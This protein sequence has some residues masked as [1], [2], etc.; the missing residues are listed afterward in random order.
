MSHRCQQDVVA[1]LPQ[2]GLPHSP[3]WVTAS[4]VLTPTDS[5]PYML[6]I[7]PGS[8]WEKQKKWQMDKA[9][10]VQKAPSSKQCFL[11]QGQSRE[12]TGP[13]LVCRSQFEY[14]WENNPEELWEAQIA[15][16]SL[17]FHL[18]M[19]HGQAFSL[20]TLALYHML[21][22]FTENYRGCKSMSP[23]RDHHFAIVFLEPSYNALWTLNCCNINSTEAVFVSISAAQNWPLSHRGN[24]DFWR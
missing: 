8:F 22:D 24:A 12:G 4:A 15:Q 1:H 14:C 9:A 3:W 18:P 23:C 6:Q 17:D 19:S 10:E 11:S 7:S 5:H 16:H 21:T 2:G 13:S 20:L